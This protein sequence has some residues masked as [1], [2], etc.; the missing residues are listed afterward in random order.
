MKTKQME[1][2]RPTLGRAGGLVVGAEDGTLPL[3]IEET[4]ACR[5]V[6][7]EVG[8]HSFQVCAELEGRQDLH[9]GHDAGCLRKSSGAGESC[10]GL[11]R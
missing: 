1:E 11:E 2:S 10:S 3:D 4:K 5:S 8:R 9:L 6:K 7:L